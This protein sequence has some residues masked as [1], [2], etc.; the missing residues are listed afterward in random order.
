MCI[1]IFATWYSAL[2]EFQCVVQFFHCITFTANRKY[3]ENLENQ[4]RHFTKLFS[5]HVANS[6]DQS[7]ILK[8]FQLIINKLVQWNTTKK[9]LGI[10]HAPVPWF[11][12]NCSQ[13]Y[14][15]LDG[16]ECKFYTLYTSWLH[17]SGKCFCEI[18]FIST[19]FFFVL[20]LFS[21]IN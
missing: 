5:I 6:K 19:T 7:P 10:R 21:T 13:H 17:P 18:K 16:L 15:L 2:H 20:F 12:K 1:L 4:K 14:T 11:Q 3:L 9:I 8:I